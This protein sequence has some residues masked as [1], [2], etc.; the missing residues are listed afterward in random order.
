MK[1][2]IFAALA[3]AAICV[4]SAD[5]ALVGFIGTVDSGRAGPVLGSLPR[6]FTL[7]LDYTPTAGGSTTINSGT[8]AFKP[9]LTNPNVIVP[10]EPT[11]GGLQINNNGGPMGQDFFTFTGRV[12]GPLLGPNNV[13]FS[14]T[15]LK[16]ADTVS[17]V[18]LN[19]TSLASLIAGPSVQIAFAGGSG[20][21]SGTGLVRGAPEP[22]TMIALCGLVVG[23]CGVGYR[24]RLRKAQAAA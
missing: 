1:Y 15:F 14:F 7:V 20:G 5:A 16:P 9:T 2:R 17:S 22:S 21:F 10:L 8:L 23:G 24:R 6:N 4:S 11:F 19:P 3:F 18:D 12:N 13:N